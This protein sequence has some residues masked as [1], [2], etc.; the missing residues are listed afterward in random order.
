MGLATCREEDW[1]RALE[2]MDLMLEAIR[3]AGR[4][5]GN[6]AAL[7]GAQYIAVPR[8]EAKVAGYTVLH[9]RS[10]T[11]RGVALLDTASGQRV[12]ATTTD[13][14]LIARMES[15]ECVGAPLQVAG[16]QRC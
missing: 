11:P 12:L 14:L 6:S 16:A 10:R 3:A 7:A 4:D 13:P 15:S 8:G 9:G 1:T 2:P 5:A